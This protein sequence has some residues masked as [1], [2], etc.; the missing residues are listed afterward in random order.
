MRKISIFAVIVILAGVISF[1]PQAFGQGR[2]K[3]LM[4][5]REGYSADLDLMI[6]ME[7]EV[8]RLLL[9]NAGLDVD[10]ATSS[11]LPIVGP[12]EKVTD[13][14]WLRNINVD[15]YAGVMIP[16]MAVGGAVQPYPPVPPEVIAIVK[17]ALSNGK[18][19]A[20]NGNAPVTLAEAGVLKG[21]KYSFMR[22]PLKPTAT[23]PF[24][25]PA[26]E[27]AIYSGSGLVQDGLIITSGVC[28]ALERFFGMENRTVK[29]TK[30]FI[31]AV[32]KK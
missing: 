3:V 1:S 10:I 23:V 32:P 15:D 13:I 7:I 27:G 2:S 29:L 20:A 24:P 14:K 30:A 9:K 21:K 28:P 31:A 11:G 22:D 8:M 17:K 18:P 16:C 19:V 25:F 26:F 12:T 4:I 6:K 5:P